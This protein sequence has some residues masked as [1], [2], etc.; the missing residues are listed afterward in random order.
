LKAGI[1]DPGDSDILLVK[2]DLITDT[3]FS[4]IILWDGNA[5]YTPSVPLLKGTKREFYLDKK[6]IH[7]RDIRLNELHYFKKIRLINAMLDIGEGEDIPVG[8]IIG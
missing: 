5:W 1:P 7:L 4:N 2:N 8:N 3:S 6:I